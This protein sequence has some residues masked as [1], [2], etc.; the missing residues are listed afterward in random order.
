MLI[1]CCPDSS[2]YLSSTNKR[3][4]P[5]VRIILVSLNSKTTLQDF[6]P[7]DTSLCPIP[8]KANIIAS[9]IE[10]LPIPDFPDNNTIPVLPKSIV[11]SSQHLKLYNCISI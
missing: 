1:I 11:F 6:F 2:S 4:G 8:N 9:N 5:F 10:V 7:M 3:F